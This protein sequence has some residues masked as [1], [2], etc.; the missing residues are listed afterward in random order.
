MSSN[1]FGQFSETVQ[2]VTVNSTQAI[3]GKKRFLNDGNEFAGV[4]LDPTIVANNQSIT[5]L[6]L[7]Y[8]NGLT[9]N[10]QEQFDN[11]NPVPPTLQA[12]L[13]EGNSA[14]DS[15]M[16][17]SAANSSVTFSASAINFANTSTSETASITEATVTV[18][19]P[20]LDLH[21]VI[22]PNSITLNSGSVAVSG[23][24]LSGGSIS[25]YSSSGSNNTALY[26]GN[27]TAN[28]GSKV[29]QLMP[30]TI[31]LCLM[32]GQTQTRYLRQGTLYKI[33]EPIKR[34]TLLFPKRRPAEWDPFAKI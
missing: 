3:L 8:L 30:S 1:I 10:I 13:D 15:T 31:R 26:A 22:V 16:S 4:F 9:G 17:L 19:N 34:I 33:T 21:T 11:F 24:N 32:T 18:E 2:S 28:S 7:S 23:A 27:I 12:V 14:V 25:V 20:D 5:S 6:E 29:F